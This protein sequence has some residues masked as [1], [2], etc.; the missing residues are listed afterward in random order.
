MALNE[1][2]IVLFVLMCCMFLYANLI[3]PFY[4]NKTLCNC[5]IIF[6]LWGISQYFTD[7][8]GL[9]ELILVGVAFLCGLINHFYWGIALQL[10][11]DF[12]RSIIAMTQFLNKQKDSKI[13]EQD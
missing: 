8:I 6:V 9:E 7:R 2:N 4:P 10:D 12:N 1:K 5:N 3:N 11:E 13:K